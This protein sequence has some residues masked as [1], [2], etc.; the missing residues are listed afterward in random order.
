MKVIRWSQTIGMPLMALLLAT[1]CSDPKA[2]TVDDEIEESSAIAVNTVTL[3]STTFIETID[4]TGETEPIRSANLSAE[5][6]GRVTTYNLE[7]GDSVK[8]GD[9]LMIVDTRQSKAQIAQMRAE[10]DNADVEIARTERLIERGL[11]S[12]QQ[13]EQLRTQR[14]STNQAIRSANVG[15]GNARVRAP[16]SGI[17]LEEHSEVGEYLGVGAAVA[18]IA[19]LSTIKVMVNLPERELRYVE[20]GHKAD[21]M[22]PALGETFEGIV[23]RI[24]MEADGRNRSFPVEI[25][26][27]NQDGRIRAGMRA[28][29]LLHKRSVED[30][31]VIP[32]DVVRQGSASAEALIVE[33]GK[34]VVRDVTLGSAYGRYIIVHSGLSAGEELVI[35]G[36]RELI[37]GQSVEANNEGKCCREQLSKAR[38]AAGLQANAGKAS[39][40]SPSEEQESATP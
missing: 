6:A 38:E 14:E 28:D 26:I 2:K 1:A 13:L 34:A 27:D 21:V 17:V 12:T 35:R 9:T 25:H 39:V 31:I 10:L 18:R 32:R 3:E 30:A 33:D 20:Q 19:D 15:V 4:L 16:F 40:P 37:G 29:A 5:M 7:A 8:K 22:I 23:M 24:G 36:Q 11:A